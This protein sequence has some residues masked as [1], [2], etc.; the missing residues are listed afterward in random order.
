MDDLERGVKEY[1]TFAVSQLDTKRPK[2]LIML[3]SGNLSA[4]VGQG[5]QEVPD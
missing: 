2:L 4:C 3:D 1:S 5:Y